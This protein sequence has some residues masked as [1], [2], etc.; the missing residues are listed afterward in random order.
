M[1]L[2]SVLLTFKLTGEQLHETVTVFDPCAAK[3]KLALAGQVVG[4]TVIV[5][6]AICPEARVPLDGEKLIPCIPLPDADQFKLGS[7][8]LLELK[9]RVSVHVQ[10][11]VAS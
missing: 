10:P 7:P 4:G 1:P 11:L 6:C 2:N 3:L 8:G 9:D 5:T